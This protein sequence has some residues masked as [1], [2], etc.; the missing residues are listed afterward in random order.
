MQEQPRVL[1]VEDDAMTALLLSNVMTEMGCEVIGLAS[2]GPRGVALADYH[3][4]DLALVDVKLAKGTDG[5]AAARQ[6]R[7]ELKL[8][9]V[10]VSGTQP[11][12]LDGQDD[13]LPLVRK[14]FDTMQ[15]KTAVRRM[16]E[17]KASP[18]VAL[19]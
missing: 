15:I 7:R 1:I 3:R 8:D 14:P 16:L 11:E 4:P 12:D 6:M 5:F 17:R 9:V 19:C 18:E 13:D 2:T 10:L